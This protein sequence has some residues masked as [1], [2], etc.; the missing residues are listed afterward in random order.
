MTAAAG[1]RLADAPRLVAVGSKPPSPL[2][3]PSPK[4]GGT[5]SGRLGER[6]VERQPLR[7]TCYNM[8]ET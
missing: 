4:G 5:S 7:R 2:P 6:A 3:N 1:A 8:R